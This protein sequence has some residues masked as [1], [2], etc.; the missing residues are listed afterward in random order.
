[1]KYLNPL[2]PDQLYQ[3]AKSSH[4]LDFEDYKSFFS[5]KIEEISRHAIGPYYWFIGDNTKMMITTA[6]ENIGEFSPYSQKEWE[7]KPTLFLAE[8]ICEEDRFY[9]LSAFQLA[10]EK[11]IQTPV[12]RQENVRVN[13]YA[14]MAN[15]NREYRWVLIQIPSIYINYEGKEVTT[16]ALVMVTDLSHL[17]FSERP[18][19]MTIT[20]RVANQNQYFHIVKDEMKLVNYNLPNIT[21]REQELLQLMAKGLNSPEMAKQLFLSHHTI[22]QHLRNLRKK[23]KTK[24]SA[25]LMAFVCKNNLF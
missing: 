22:E 8:N 7:N 1:M 17:T 11:I 19:M 12:E 23:T 18:V 9:V 16:C 25:E 20:D 13:I 2:T 24:T 14:R 5:D 6:S 10:V 4:K 21:K 15:A 3:I